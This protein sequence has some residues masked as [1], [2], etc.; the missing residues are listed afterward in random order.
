MKQ[1]E[2]QG[3][4]GC[5][6]Y[7]IIPDNGKMFVRK[8]SKNFQYNER[9]KKQ[10]EKQKNYKGDYSFT[11]VIFNEGIIDDLYYF[12]ME[13]IVG[14]ITSSLLMKSWPIGKIN[15]LTDFLVNVIKENKESEVIDSNVSVIVENKIK[16]LFDKVKLHRDDGAIKTAFKILSEHNWSN[17]RKSKSHG[18]FTLENIIYSTNNEFYLIDFLDAFY[19]T[20]ISDASKVLFDLLI[21]WSFRMEFVKTD[22]VSENTKVRVLLLSKQF[23]ER[24]DNILDDDKLW[25]DIYSYFLLELLRVI[26]YITDKKIFSFIHKSLETIIKTIKRG[27]LYEH[28]NNTLCWPVYEISGG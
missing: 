11:P 16:N 1:I 8:I 2:L 19:D 17:L 20:W 24:F 3:H 5:K 25:E 9:L 7:L 15:S 12:D 27:G 4:S 10:C 21:G 22:A 18:D 26:P 6:V 28:I 13:Y 23:I 14:D